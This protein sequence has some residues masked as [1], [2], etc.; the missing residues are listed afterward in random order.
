MPESGNSGELIILALKEA[1]TSH[2]F[3][4]NGA[5]IWPMLI[6]AVEH[7]IRI[8]DTRHEQTAT[9]AAEG[10]SKV[11]RQCGVATVTASA[12]ALCNPAT[13]TRLCDRKKFGMVG[14]RTVTLS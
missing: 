3:T 4:L 7:G 11:T 1:G 13:F 6:G 12:E 5:H 10:W 2:L 8:V 14:V 9:F